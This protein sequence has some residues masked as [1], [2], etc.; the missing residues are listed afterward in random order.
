M[1]IVSHP[2]KPYIPKRPVN[3]NPEPF[4]KLSP[5]VYSD[6]TIKFPERKPQEY[7]VGNGA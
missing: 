6:G 4:I 1:R 3:E 5:V 2:K 7:Q